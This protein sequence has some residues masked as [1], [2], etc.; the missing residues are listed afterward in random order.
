MASKAAVE[1]I[2]LAKTISQWLPVEW[3]GFRYWC[4]HPDESVKTR[5][6][7]EEQK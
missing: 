1:A 7:S 4:H 2:G 3:K 5:M 6:A